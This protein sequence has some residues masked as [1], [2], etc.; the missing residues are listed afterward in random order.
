MIYLKKFNENSNN[1]YFKLVKPDIFHYDVKWDNE[2]I[3][4]ITCTDTKLTYLIDMEIRDYGVK[5]ISLYNIKGPD[6]IEMTVSYYISAVDVHGSLE[7]D[8]RETIVMVQLDWNKAKI[9]KETELGAITVN[10]VTIE[11]TN[12]NTGKIIAKEINVKVFDI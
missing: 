2:D 5:S 12:D 6:E 11:L 1:T 8:I 7:D 4:D 3:E 10:D 9:E